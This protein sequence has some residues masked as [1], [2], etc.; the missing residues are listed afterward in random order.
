M[1][2]E[3]VMMSNHLILCCPLLFLHSIFPSIRVFSNELNELAL[4]IR[5]LIVWTSSQVFC[6]MPLSWGVFL[7]IRLG[8]QVFGRKT[9]HEGHPSSHHIQRTYYQCDLSLLV[10]ILSSWL[11]QY[12][13]VFPMA[14]SLLFSQFHRRKEVTRHNPHL[15]SG[16]QSHF[17]CFVCKYFLRF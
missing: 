7:M 3:S 12:L 13:S 2:I 9:P 8:L 17:S 5:W 6:R 10:L 1:F 4:H 11:R 15:R 14:E 16:G